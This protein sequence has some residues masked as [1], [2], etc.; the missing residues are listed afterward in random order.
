MLRELKDLKEDFSRMK[1]NNPSSDKEKKKEEK[2]DEEE[3]KEENCVKDEDEE[4]DWDNEKTIEVME[5]AKR[6]SW[7]SER[8]KNKVNHELPESIHVNELERKWW[9]DAGEKREMYDY[10]QWRGDSVGTLKN[11]VLKR[12]VH[13]L[14]FFFL[15]GREGRHQFY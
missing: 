2:N 5:K 7:L 4:W 1:G 3:S 14:Y 15:M 10:G 12:Y 9:K 13:G 8:Q 6:E 11:E